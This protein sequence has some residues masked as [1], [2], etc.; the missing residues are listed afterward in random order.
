MKKCYIFKDDGMWK[1]GYYT[2]IS[3]DDALFEIQGEY[4]TWAEAVH[5]MITWQLGVK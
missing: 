1:W 3:V 4:N 5:D 2:Q